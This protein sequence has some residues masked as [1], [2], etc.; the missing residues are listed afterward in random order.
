MPLTTWHLGWRVLAYVTATLA[1]CGCAFSLKTREETLQ[2]EMTGGAAGTNSVALNPYRDARF[3]LG[4]ICPTTK[5]GF[6]FAPLVPLPP[7]LPGAVVA[8]KGLDRAEMKIQVP[9]GADSWLATLK[10]VDTGSKQVPIPLDGTDVSRTELLEPY[11]VQFIVK[12]AA[13]CRE[14]D[15]G[16]LRVDAQRI[17]GTTLPAVAVKLRLATKD[18]VT[19]SCG[20][21]L[22]GLTSRYSCPW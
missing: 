2:F 5:P 11:G 1:V 19:T 15:G 12:L 14:L 20:V 4:F 21:P 13:T 6:M 17:A 18:E 16:E 8:K 10:V 22:P 9:L 7:V 3:S